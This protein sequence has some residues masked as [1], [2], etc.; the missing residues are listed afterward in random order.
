MSKDALRSTFLKPLVKAGVAGLVTRGVYGNN[1]VIAFGQ[2]WSTMTFGAGLGLASEGVTQIINM[3]VLPRLE[4]NNKA[5]HFESLVV[6][7]GISA[8][9]FALLPMLV[10]G[11]KPTGGEMA[12]LA[13]I[14]AATEVLSTYIY[15][16]LWG[17][18]EGMTPLL[19]LY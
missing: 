3:W 11:D 14:G 12:T 4:P 8:G 5:R 1:Q 6:S 9:S 2:S 17:S 7:L 10:G 19:A 15:D 18:A 16:N 13:G